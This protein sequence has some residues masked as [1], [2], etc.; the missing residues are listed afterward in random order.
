MS[1]FVSRRRFTRAFYRQSSLV[2]AQRLLGCYLHREVNGVELVGKIVETEAYGPNDEACHAFRGR[3]QR[4]A[5]MFGDGGYSYVYFTYGMHHC[6]NV[7]TSEEGTGEAVL[8]RAVEPVVGLEMMR[9]LRPKASREVDIA[10]GPGKLCQAFGLSR[11]DNGLD[12]IESQELFITIGEALSA[13]AIGVSTRIGISVAV[14]HPWRY[15]VKGSNYVS[16]GKPSGG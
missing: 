11:G 3:T 15:Y 14:D 2:V 1:A 7:T 5:V 8:I 4:N 10:N 6:F 12:L 16:R 13:D 9:Q